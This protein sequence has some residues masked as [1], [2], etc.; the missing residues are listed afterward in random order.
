MTTRSLPESDVGSSKDDLAC[1]SCFKTYQRPGIN[2]R[3]GDLLMRHRRR[4]QG[5]RMPTSRRK[6]CNACVLAKTKCCY[7][8]PTC[9][10]CSKRGIQCVYSISPTASTVDHSGPPRE[11]AENSSS[12]LQ[13]PSRLA[14]PANLGQPFE[15]DLPAWD[16]SAS[17]YSLENFEMTMADLERPLPA[18]V[19]SFTLMQPPIAHDSREITPSSQT[20]HLSATTSGISSFAP[21]SS[22]NA[23]SSAVPSS[24]TSVGLIRVLSEYPSLLMKESFFSPFLHFSQYSL[25]NNIVPDMTFL[26]QTA[27]A[28]CC[29]SGINR[30][31]NNRFFRRAI[32]AARER[33]IGSFP[34][35]QCMQQWDALHAMLI[36]ESLELKEGIRDESEA[37]KHNPRVNGLGSAFLLKMI[38]FY[39]RS[40][41]EIRNPDITVFSD[42]RSC[43]CPAA[44]STWARWRITETARR[45]VFFANIVNFYSNRDHS[46]REQFLYYEPL[47]DDLI[48]N[49]PLPCNEPA[50]LARNEE[51]WRLAMERPTTSASPSRGFNK[52]T[53]EALFSEMSLRTAFS[54]LSKESL[55]AEIGTSVGFGDSDELRR[56]IVLGASDQYS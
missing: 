23:S 52:P 56:L 21:P 46:K 49:M 39:L 38:K 17:S 27:M 18:A 35:F 51:E 4:C 47:D 32:D 28:I 29:S 22:D 40:Y 26:P 5:P 33:V 11:A 15:L 30:S 8:Q 12:A 45:T 44:T 9:T 10:R 55:R 41:P 2:S 20:L 16:F 37:W 1:E 25:Y 3:V 13:P 14:N 24:S 31:D 7:T 36:Y 42:P 53:C 34:T 50:W 19:S 6:A 48:L 43:P 54:N